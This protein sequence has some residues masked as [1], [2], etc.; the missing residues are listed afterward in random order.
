MEMLSTTGRI[1]H[2]VKR[3]YKSTCTRPALC[4]DESGP[5][6][7]NVAG[8]KATW[9]PR[10]VTLNF[11]LSASRRASLSLTPQITEKATPPRL[12]HHHRNASNQA[13][14]DANVNST[15]CAHYTALTGVCSLKRSSYYDS[16]YRQS[17]ALIRARRPYLF[18]NMAVGSAIFVFVIGVCTCMVQK[19]LVTKFAYNQQ[20][21]SQLMRSGKINSKM[22][23]CQI[24]LSGHRRTPMPQEMAADDMKCQERPTFNTR[25]PAVAIFRTS[26]L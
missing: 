26:E 21:R 3:K 6:R 16:D 8:C 7:F 24:H 17:A 1:V 12:Y 2:C 14:D 9:R 25:R 4:S 11:A 13:L 23:L 18:K 5:E 10:N 22:S 15:T 20:F 19:R